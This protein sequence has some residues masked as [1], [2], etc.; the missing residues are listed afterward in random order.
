VKTVPTVQL[1]D[2]ADTAGLG[3]PDQV[4]LAVGDIAGVVWEG[5]L[6]MRVAAGVRGV[7][8]HVRGRD[9]RGGRAEGQA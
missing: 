5:L 4:R 8:N 6:A 1:A 9:H 2:P 7:A 3:L